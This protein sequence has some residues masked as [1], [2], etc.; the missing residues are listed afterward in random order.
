M[1]V[2]LCI[3]TLFWMQKMREAIIQLLTVETFSA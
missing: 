2:W 3:N 1:Q